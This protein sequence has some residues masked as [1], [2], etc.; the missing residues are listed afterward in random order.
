MANSEVLP[1]ASVAV[2]DTA[3]PWLSTIGTTTE[4]WM[5]NSV[6]HGGVMLWIDLAEGMPL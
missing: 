1:K 3:V 2:A 5:V 6:L 4:N